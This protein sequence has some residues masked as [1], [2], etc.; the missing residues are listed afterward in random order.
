MKNNDELFEDIYRKYNY[1]KDKKNNKFFHTSVYK[2]TSNSILRAVAMLFV[3]VLSASIISVSGLGVYAVFGGKISGIPVIEWLG[4]KFSDEYSN[5]VVPI[6]DKEIVNHETKMELVSAMCNEG[7]TVLEFNVTL[8][9]EDKNTLRIG[10]KILSDERIAKLEESGYK[11]NGQEKEYVNSL[12]VIFNAKE[13]R[14]G[15]NNFTVN[16][17]DEEFWIRPRGQQ[18]V[19]KISDYEFKVY[20]FYFLTDKEL[21]D[22]TDFKF[23]LKN[24]VLTNGVNLNEIEMPKNGGVLTNVPENEQSIEID[25]EFEVQ[26]S[27]AK[28]LENSTIIDNIDEEASYKHITERVKRV[29]ITPMQIL[30]EIRIDLEGI[31]SSNV[32]DKSIF[33]EQYKVYTDSGEE[34]E[35]SMFET[36]RHLIYANGKEEDWEVGDVRYVGN[37][38]NAKMELTDY[39]A[40]EKKPNIKSLKIVPSISNLRNENREEIEVTLDE[41]NIDLENA[42]SA[43]NT[44]NTSDTSN[45]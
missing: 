11:I 20:Q 10:E 23:T 34:L 16:I 25:G 33:N 1:Y 22:K 19:E 27:K 18:R 4:I 9:E 5:Y 40:L 14:I 12:N 32:G 26:L 36:R 21:G 8:S 35:Q 30:I 24:I 37:F 17:D 15:T 44:V 42:N 3:I 39:I 43:E 45:E 28:A 6:E 31:S 41:M 2:K 13:N 7:Y 29:I 38:S